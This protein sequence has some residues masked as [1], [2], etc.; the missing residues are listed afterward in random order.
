M[1]DTMNGSDEQSPAQAAALTLRQLPERVR[2]I[3]TLRGLGYSYRKIAE[4]FGVTPQ[5]VSVM[6]SRHRHSLADLRRHPEFAELSPRAVNAL[7]KHG[8]RSRADARGRNVSDL[9]QGQRNC[10][11]K[12]LEEIAR[13]LD[14]AVVPRDGAHGRLEPAP[15]TT[16]PSLIFT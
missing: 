10:G 14:R 13:W 4:A 11:R 9:L 15:P 6:L 8:I 1:Y 16:D 7:A 3:A 5:A 12:T 2:D